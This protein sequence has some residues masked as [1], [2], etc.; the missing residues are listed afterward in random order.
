VFFGRVEAVAVL[1][2]KAEIEVTVYLETG[3]K[4]TVVRAGRVP[5]LRPI[6]SQEDLAWHADQYAQ[7]TIA[8]DLTELGWEVIAGSEIPQPEGGAA[9]K[10]A[11][12]AVRRVGYPQD[13]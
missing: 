5:L 3:K 10:S 2:G 9:A 7:E 11:S 6:G 4:I 8:V 12:Y 1:A 13:Q